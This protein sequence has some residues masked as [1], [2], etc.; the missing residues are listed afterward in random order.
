MV[1]RDARFDMFQ[2][3]VSIR[4]FLGDDPD[5]VDVDHKLKRIG[6]IKLL[7]TT[8]GCSSFFTFLELSQPLC[9]LEAAEVVPE[10]SAVLL[11]LTEHSQKVLPPQDFHADFHA[12]T[13][14]V[15]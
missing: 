10:I 15:F 7:P 11:V 4:V 3:V 6:L 8:R 9:T 14:T 5:N 13:L 1:G 2:I 12:V